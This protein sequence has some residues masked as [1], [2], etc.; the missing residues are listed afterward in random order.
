VSDPRSTTDWYDIRMGQ[1]L[2]LLYSY[3]KV[4]D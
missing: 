2:V 1:G 3:R 4:K